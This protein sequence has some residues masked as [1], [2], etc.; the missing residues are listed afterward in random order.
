[1]H[2]LS[3][4]QQ[5]GALVHS[6]RLIICVFVSILL[7]S[8]CGTKEMMTKSALGCPMRDLEI[9]PSDFE[10]AGSRTNW[11]AKCEGKTFWCTTNAAR[12]KLTCREVVAGRAP[13]LIR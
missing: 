1:M 4:E 6:I 10:R 3:D 11:C 12:S 7:I 9:I 8:S 5:T 13:C 2:T